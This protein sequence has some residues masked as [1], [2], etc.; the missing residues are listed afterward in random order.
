MVSQERARATRDR[1]MMAAADAFERIGFASTS[2][3]D[4]ADIAGVTKGAVYFHFPSKDA[5]AL[6]VIAAEH[7]L[8]SASASA[9]M[10][11]TECPLECAVMLSADLARRLQTDPIVRAGIRLT[12]ESSRLDAPI[13]EPYEDWLATFEAL[14]R[15]AVDRGEVRSDIDPAALARFIIPSFTGI[16]MV[17]ELFSGR[18]DLPERVGQMWGF[19]L[20][21]IVPADRLDDAVA[22]VAVHLPESVT[23]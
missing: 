13:R 21:G 3:A 11:A 14:V 15:R 17:S 4:I 7:A 5:V 9:I 16:Q 10:A 1:I 6:A 19:I 2:L 22:M 12:T 23:G 8:A 18:A 20:P